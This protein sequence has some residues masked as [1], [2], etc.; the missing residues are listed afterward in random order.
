MNIPVLTFFVTALWDVILRIY[1]Q[2]NIK[3]KPDF[4]KALIPYFKYHSV[5]G[6]AVI[7]GLVGYFTQIV[8]LQFVKFPKTFFDFKFLLIS[9]I[10]SGLI[11]YPLDYFRIIP[12]LSDTYYKTLGR[13]RSFFTDGYSGLV[14]QLSLVFL[15]N[16]LCTKSKPL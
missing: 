8:I 10:I 16:I 4:V 6:A 7:A 9:F 13:P 3:N 15:L 1:A 12:S 5:I 14:V 11:G 2:S